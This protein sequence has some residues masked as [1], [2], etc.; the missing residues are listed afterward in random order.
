MRTLIFGHRGASHEAPENTLSAFRLAR[1]MGADGVELDVQL[2]R[3]GTVI[4][5]H[6]SAVDR[7]TDGEGEVEDLTLKQLR[8]LDAGSWFSSAFA[9][10]SIPTLKEVF[11]AVGHHMLMNLELKAISSDP[12]GLEE[13][14]VALIA[15]HG[16]GEQ[17][18]ISCFNPLVLERVRALD[19]HLSLAFLYGPRL[20]EEKR[21]RWVQ[22]LQPLAALHPEYHLVDAD[23]LAWAHAQ[24]CSVNTWT[25]D[26]PAEMERLLSLGIEGIITDRPDLLRAI[27]ETRGST[28]TAEHA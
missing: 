21:A 2:S 23:H 3:D 7:T 6:D 19:P 26:D 24:G 5:M 16:M 10:E 9:G 14:V 22:D 20:P 8:E 25:V 12:T 18:L 28:T 13:T 1:D 11:G 17:V 4:V 27:M 15:K